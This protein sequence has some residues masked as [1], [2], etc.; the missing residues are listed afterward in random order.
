M[1]LIQKIINYKF[2]VKLNTSENIYDNVTYE[3]KNTDEFSYMIDKAVD[4]FFENHLIRFSA[5]G[6]DVIVPHKGIYI[7]FILVKPS[8]SYN[9]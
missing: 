4:K 7:R 8:Y 9:L 1:K 5:L 3:P 2:S 6:K